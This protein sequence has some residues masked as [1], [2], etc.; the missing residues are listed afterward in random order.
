[1]QNPSLF[2]PIISFFK[3]N[4]RAVRKRAGTSTRKVEN[5]FLEGALKRGNNTDFSIDGTD[6]VIDE[7]TWLIGK[8]ELGKLARVKTR[9]QMDGMLYATKVII[10]S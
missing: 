9:V 7:N 5:N 4:T 3:P 10:L 2:E 6:V 1:M 8:L